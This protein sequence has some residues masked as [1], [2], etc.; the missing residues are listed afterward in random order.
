MASG[1][2]PSEE[3]LARAWD[4]LQAHGMAVDMVIICCARTSVQDMIARSLQ[5][6]TCVLKSDRPN[7]L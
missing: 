6:D 4:N 3:E 2:P 1:A 7:T 5:N